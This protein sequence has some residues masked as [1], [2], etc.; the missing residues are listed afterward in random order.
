M[1]LRYVVAI[2]A[3]TLFSAGAIASEVVVGAAASPT[4][5]CSNWL[6]QNDGSYWRECV[7]DDGRQ[8][9]EVSQNGR[10]SRVS[11]K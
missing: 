6:K 2:F 11:C 7:G 10:I 4:P 1:N 9:C 8:Y 3:L 5:S